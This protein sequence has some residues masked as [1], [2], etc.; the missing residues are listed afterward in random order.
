MEP[1]IQIPQRLGF[2]PYKCLYRVLQPRERIGV[3]LRRQ[4]PT[5]TISGYRNSGRFAL[6]INTLPL[7]EIDL[8]NLSTRPF[9]LG[10]QGVDTSYLIP[11]SLRQFLIVSLMPCLLL[12]QNHFMPPIINFFTKAT[13]ASKMGSKVCC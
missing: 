4:I 11:L 5:I 9:Q 12:D 1:K 3:W 10:L 13:V 2:F 8:P 7:L 6:H